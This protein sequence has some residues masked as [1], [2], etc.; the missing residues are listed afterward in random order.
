MIYK[1]GKN[2]LED[3]SV[4][5][6]DKKNDLPVGT[7]LQ[8]H[9]YSNP[10]YVII[11]NLGVNEKF[12][13][14]GARY[15]SV[16]L[17][18]NTFSQ[19]DAFSMDHIDTKKDNRIHM[20]YTDEVMPLDDVLEIWEKAKH[21]DQQKKEAQEK[22]AIIANEKEAR[23][24]QLFA[25]HIPENAQALIVAEYEVDKCDLQTDYF[26]TSTTQTVIIG[27]SKHKRDLF[28]EMRKHADRIPETAH[29]KE[30]PAVDSNNEPKTE[31][32]KSWWHPADEH[33]EKYSMGH[34]YYLKAVGRYSTGWMIHKIG[35]YGKDDWSSGLYISMAERCVFE[36]KKG[37]D[38]V[39]IEQAI[40][41]IAKR[42][43]I[44]I[45][46]KDLAITLR[47]AM[48]QSQC[49]DLVAM[50]GFLVGQK[51]SPAKIL[52]ELYH[53]LNGFKQ[54]YL[55][56]GSENGFSRNAGS[57]P[58]QGFMK[59]QNNTLFGQLD[60]IAI[61]RLKTFEPQKGYWVA[62]SGGKDSDVVLDLI[63]RSGVKYDAHHSLTTAD[64][65]E[66][67]RHVKE[68]P[69]VEIHRPKRSMWELVKKSCRPPMRQSRFCC[70]TQKES[71]GSGRL[72]V[73]GIRRA[74]GANRSNRK[75]VEFCYRDRTKR[76]LNVIV[77]WTTTDVWQYIKSRNISYCSL[78]DEG[79]KRLGCVLCPMKRDVWRDLKRWP[80]MCRAW[81]R[82]IK[83]SFRPDKTPF[84]GPDEYWQW[85]LT[86]DSSAKDKNELLF[87]TFIEDETD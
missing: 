35:K 40:V 28:S 20:Y 41:E 22:A 66:L 1:I 80:K 3:I 76:Y 5:E 52:T 38:A 85:W 58:A 31:S 16:K 17:D 32:N 27:W 44:S 12:K 53:D 13:S 18:D 9:G 48:N 71:G 19:H 61:E 37:T 82:A 15:M 4:T 39:L 6:D 21:K 51:M 24:R 75:M 10:R 87:K 67:V 42:A 74:E 50:M 59:N 54:M 70:Q 26:S 64:P 30:V 34:G 57:T 73:T 46:R 56:P 69:D 47:V 14:H 33:R 72:V 11:K 77:D 78:Y 86:R 55:N 83:A 79:F 25:K 43:D 81:E 60:E 68:Q 29:L 36:K 65:P 2:G 7:V 45:D 49:E 8:L 62:Y 84:G 23:G 63:R